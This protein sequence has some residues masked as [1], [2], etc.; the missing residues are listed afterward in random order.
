MNGILA[1]GDLHGRADLLHKAL[2]QVVPK[3]QPVTL[4][5]L[6]DYVDRGP[7]SST[8]VNS[9]IKI[10]DQ[11]PETI[12][13]KGNHERT[14]LSAIR[15][16]YYQGN[17]LDNGGQ[18]TLDSYGLSLKN[19]RD[20]PEKHRKFLEELPLYH[21]TDRYIFVHAGLRPGIPLVKQKTEDLLTIREEFYNTNK[22]FGKMVVF[23]HTFFREPLRKKNLLGIDT[24][25]VYGNYLTCVLLPKMQFF[26]ISS[27]KPN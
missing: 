13:L 6:G 21:E 14:L 25:A 26:K 24:G 23:G 4:A 5:F 10:K 3:I 8:V 1:I 7:D 16:Y 27:I 15:S 2:T 11:F 22:P 9:L 18:A 20:F 17:F 19:L 12:I